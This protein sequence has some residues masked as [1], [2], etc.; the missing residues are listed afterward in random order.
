[1]I[2]VSKDIVNALKTIYP[3]YYE[4]FC[5]ENT[6][7]PCITYMIQ[8]DNQGPTGD[9]FGYSNVRYTI[10]LWGDDLSVL[11]PKAIEIDEVL[12]DLGLRRISLN[13]LTFDSHICKIFVY[14]GLCREYFTN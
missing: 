5:D 6:A 4:L 12:R 9:T 10:K 13:E 2:D 1:M 14:E 11:N 3:T 7:K 8:D